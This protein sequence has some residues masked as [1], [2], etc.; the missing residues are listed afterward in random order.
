MTT[1]A[2]ITF[3]PMLGQILGPDGS[4]SYSDFCLTIFSFL[5]HF[6]FAVFLIVA[7]MATVVGSTYL[8]H[9]LFTLPMRRA[10]R[11]RLFLDLLE[12]ALNRGQSVEEMIL[13][14]AQSR[15]QTVGVRF[16]LL[17]A[18]LEA[19]LKFGEA[20]EKAPRFLPPQISA[21]LQAGGELGDLEKVLPACREILRDRPAAVRSAMHYLILVVLFFSPVFI[22]VVM[23]TTTFVVPR[24][25]DVAANMGV[26]LWPA[27]TFVFVLADSGFLTGLE[28]VI[29]LLMSGVVLFYIGGPQFARWFQFRSV[30]AVDWIAWRIP[31]KQKRL[32]RTFSAMLAV[33]LDGGVP[34]AVAVRLAGDC[35][36]N[37][38][39]R[40]RSQRV[41][42][43]IQ[44]GTKLDDAVLAFDASG[45]FHWRL[46]NA[47]HV[48]GGF[49]NA[50]R[51]WHEALDAK[52][53]QLEE[54]TAHTVTTGIVI[55]NGVLVALIATAMFG[56][57]LAVLNGVLASE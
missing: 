17:A 35:T 46:T 51:G 13:S 9:F 34:E 33:L 36:A 48:H 28:V 8:I 5:F 29:S 55:L 6:I 42:A 2:A 30:P 10:E 22:F 31:W 16:H 45:E 14:V 3:S 43:A 25:K 41:V 38:I 11:A 1:D 57:L 32:Q 49:L 27:T 21:M 37:E 12:G 26:Q 52:A 40:R 39:C 53:F 23:M 18:H 24:F 50:L 15:D 20:L 4:F 47:A 7:S 54:A 19:G 56:I 44:Q